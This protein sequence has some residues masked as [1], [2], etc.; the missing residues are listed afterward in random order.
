MDSIEAQLHN[1]IAN[2]LPG[3]E[4]HL[5]MSPVT[6]GLSS[7]ARRQAKN[8]RTSGIAIV[9]FRKQENNSLS[10]ILIRRSEYK[11]A[12]SG[13]ISFPGG[14]KEELDDTLEDTA[15]RECLEEI[16]VDLTL[17]RKLGKM[18]SVY[19]PVSNFDIEPFVFYL[20]DEPDFIRDER[21]VQ[22]IFAVTIEDLLDDNN[23][24]TM[25]IY[26]GEGIAPMKVPCFRFGSY[27]VWGAT[28]IILNELKTLFRLLA[29]SE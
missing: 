25:V 10:F 27:E 26:L 21:E 28:A 3:E 29:V 16:G 23:I 5:A 7:V 15:I 11:G 1:A 4:A 6:R 17:S 22:E 8:I 19:V 13:Q 12:H 18:T 2:Y 14:K 20:E 9:L 24:D